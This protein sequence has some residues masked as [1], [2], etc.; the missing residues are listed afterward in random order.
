M[1]TR[2]Y[3]V[4]VMTSRRDGPLYV[5]VTNDLAKR[6]WQHREGQLPGFTRR[7]GLKRLVHF[8]TFE[9]VNEAIAFEKRLKRW[10][11]VWKIELIERDNPDWLDLWPDIAAP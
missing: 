6:V 1:L 8:E 10:R 5:G 4:Y 11:R 7:Y 2:T 9:D 3:A